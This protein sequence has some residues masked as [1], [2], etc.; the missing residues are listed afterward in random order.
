[1]ID[2]AQNRKI[3]IRQGTRQ[4][5]VTVPPISKVKW[6]DCL[7]LMT[8]ASGHVEAERALIDLLGKVV[9]ASDGYPNVADDPHCLS[10]IPW[11][12]RVAYANALGSA[13]PPEVNSRIVDR[14]SAEKPIH[15]HSVWSARENGGMLLHKDLVHIFKI[16][17]VHQL[18]NFRRGFPP[19]SMV[20]EKGSG[21]IQKDPLC[22]RMSS[23]LYDEF[24][25]RVE[26]YAFNGEPLG[27][28]R[29]TIVNHMDTYHKVIAVGH[30]IVD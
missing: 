7:D 17:S 10:N 21:W 25:V 9:I 5:S 8:S 29:A 23:A 3:V 27:D 19:P 16:P 1:M 6:L 26:G 22:G 4:L 15:I 24:I 28:N 20:K 2:L 18:L 12:H 11:R 13:H 30:L 14:R